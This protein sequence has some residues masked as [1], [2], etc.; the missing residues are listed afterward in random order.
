MEAANQLARSPQTPA[1]WMSEPPSCMERREPRCD[2]SVDP[3]P[4]APKTWPPHRDWGK[5]RGIV[6][7]APFPM[8]D[9]PKS[10]RRQDKF[11]PDRLTK[12]DDGVSTSQLTLPDAVKGHVWLSQS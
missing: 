8:K 6:A 9:W 4:L 11:A 1:R 7:L 5:G 2:Q 10:D 12:S 3:G